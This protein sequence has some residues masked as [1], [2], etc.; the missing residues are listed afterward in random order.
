VGVV[1]G[2]VLAA[3]AQG[4]EVKGPYRM[5]IRTGATT[6][7]NYFSNDLAEGDRSLLR[8]LQRASNEARYVGDLQALLR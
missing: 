6:T 5:E 7:V 3:G 1:L 2:A 8:E 4:Q